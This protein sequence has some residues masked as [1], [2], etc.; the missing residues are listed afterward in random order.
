MIQRFVLPVHCV[1]VLIVAIC[2]S[3]L[4]SANDG[5]STITL[6]SLLAEMTNRNAIA[7]YPLPHYTC[8]QAS[9]YDRAQTDPTNANTWFAN[10]DY[11]QFL[12]IEENEGRREWV[13]MEHDGPGCIV[14]FWLPLH[15]PQKNMKIRFYFD[16]VKTP[17]ITAN[18][19]KL[20]SG[21]SFIKPPFAFVGSDKK[22]IE[23]VAGDLYLPIPFA[24]GCKITLD[25]LPYYYVIN[26]RAYDRDVNVETF[27]MD[28]FAA[29]ANTLK[30]TEQWLEKPSFP[31]E[32]QEQ[33]KAECIEPGK[34]LAISLA[35]GPA[36]VRTLRVQID[37]NDTPQTLRSVVLEAGFDGQSTVWCPLGEFF[38][39]GSQLKPMKDWDR[40]VQKDGTL[41]ATWVMPYQK[42]GRVA[43]KNFGK[44]AIT[45]KLAVK[46][47]SWHWDDRSMYFHAGWRCQ[48]SIA[49]KKA[50]G[51]MDWNYL[52][53]M[54]RGVYVGDTLTVLNPVPE[55]YGEGD[56]RIYIDGEKMPSH[57][58]T[59]TEDYY[60]YAWGMA[61][62]FS[63]PFISMPKRDSTNGWKGYTTVSRVRLLDAIPVE[64]SLKF[65]MEIWHWAATMVDYTVGVF[66]YAQ[67]GATSNCI[68]SPKD[69]SDNLPKLDH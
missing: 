18:L 44:K 30:Q 16:G 19:H 41:I 55:W 46:T 28:G 34:E 13:I 32:G 35:A 20:L 36:A 45:A 48:K 63:S 53:M 67:P 56:E 17:A 7:R 31:T 64:K 58:G 3:G 68:P 6:K 1:F 33:L 24:K 39:C 29:A 54:G 59:G 66:W 10:K 4:A 47:S 60:G 57:M 37:P 69:A 25:G 43:I 38:G 50:T 62:Q 26:F 22:A 12:R 65:D 40:S 23:G 15:G 52:E 14:R 5:E 61:E 27:T 11:E 2:A 21:R 51:T 42:S 8:K 9:S 49:T